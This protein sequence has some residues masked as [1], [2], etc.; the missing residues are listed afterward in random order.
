Y[1]DAVRESVD[2]LYVALGTLLTHIPESFIHITEVIE[3]NA[4]KNLNTHGVEKGGKVIRREPETCSLCTKPL[5]IGEVHTYYQKD[6]VHY[7]CYGK[8]KAEFESEQEALDRG[9]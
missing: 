6:R 9:G 3:K 1:S 5:L 7:S 4:Q 8:A 2:V